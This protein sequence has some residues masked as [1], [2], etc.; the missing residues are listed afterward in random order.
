[1]TKYFRQIYGP[2]GFSHLRDDDDDDHHDSNDDDDDDD[3]GDDLEAT[4]NYRQRKRHY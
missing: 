3:N 1:M 2:I 4:P